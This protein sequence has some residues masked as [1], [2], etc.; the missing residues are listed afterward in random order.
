MRQINIPRAMMY[1]IEA[2]EQL[3]DSIIQTN[4]TIIN[5]NGRL[6]SVTKLVPVPSDRSYSGMSQYL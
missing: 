6:S 3:A 4:H 1:I 5:M 2:Q